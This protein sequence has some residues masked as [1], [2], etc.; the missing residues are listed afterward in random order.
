MT[1]MVCLPDSEKKS[2]DMFSCFDRIPACDR[3]TNG[4]TDGL[5]SC[6]SMVRAML[7]IARIIAPMRST[8][9]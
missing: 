7:C 8:A 9:R 4:Q 3:Q 1:I 5:T 2:G 6:D